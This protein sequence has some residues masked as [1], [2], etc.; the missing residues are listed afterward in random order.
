MRVRVRFR[1][2]TAT[3]EVEMFRVDDLGGGVAGPDHDAEHDRISSE[4]GSVTSRRP[5]VEE[6]TETTG[7]T[8]RPAAAWSAPQATDSGTDADLDTDLGTDLDADSAQRDAW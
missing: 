8:G 7:T 3:G 6:I 2:N 4:L 1:F 5:E